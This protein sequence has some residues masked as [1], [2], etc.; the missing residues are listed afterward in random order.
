[1]SLATSLRIS[2]WVSVLNHQAVAA[3]G[4]LELASAS[5]NRALV[6]SRVV[7]IAT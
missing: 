7:F 1:L 6:A 2:V 3:A 4:S 5:I